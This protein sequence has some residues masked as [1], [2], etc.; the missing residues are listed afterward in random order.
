M[1]TFARSDENPPEVVHGTEALRSQ[2]ERNRRHQSVSAGARA[3]WIRRNK[4]Y[5]ECLRRLLRSLV[6]P[7]KRVLNIRCQTGH[8]LD[9][10][11]PAYGVGV[12]ISPEMVAVARA[13][14]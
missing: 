1:T 9:A 13:E 12:E 14:Y 4:Y 11:R 2:N 7:G 6:E 10:I 5:Y 8:L 3:G